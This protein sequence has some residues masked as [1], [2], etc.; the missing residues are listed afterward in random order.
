MRSSMGRA[1]AL[2]V[3]GID[4]RLGER[5]RPGPSVDERAARCLGSIGT[6]RERRAG[7]GRRVVCQRD[8]VLGDRAI[9]YRVPVRRVEL[10][11]A[12]DHRRLQH[13][14]DLLPG[15][16]LL[17]GHDRPGDGHVVERHD[18]DRAEAVRHGPQRHVRVVVCVGDLLWRRERR[19]A[20]VPVGREGMGS[21]PRPWMR[22]HRPPSTMSTRARATT[23]PDC[24]STARSRACASW[25]TSSAR[26]S[27]C[28]MAHGPRPSRIGLP[29]GSKPTALSCASATF[30]V[31]GGAGLR[32][33]GGLG[34]QRLDHAAGRVQ[35]L[36]RRLRQRHVLHGRPGLLVRLRRE[37]VAVLRVRRRVAT[38]GLRRRLSDDDVLRR[39]SVPA[40]ACRCTT[41][42]RGTCVEPT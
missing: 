28:V 6:H 38:T 13:Q 12:R 42:D 20:G 33:R 40:A 29:A 32:R 37:P 27:C 25:S 16:R 21:Q 35:H 17:H 41:A 5:G 10:V 4:A 11:S 18:L 24:G 36:E 9:G 26:R 39:R 19:R 15:R 23:P 1:I 2:G 22:P 8:L 31:V 34:W 3:G 7:A 30:C 14:R